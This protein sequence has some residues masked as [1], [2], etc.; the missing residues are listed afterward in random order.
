MEPLEFYWAVTSDVGGKLVALFEGARREEAN[1]LAA[2]QGHWEV[3]FAT[4]QGCI[5]I[6]P[7]A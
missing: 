7:K 1:A 4:V 6:G 3:R 2:T 5:H